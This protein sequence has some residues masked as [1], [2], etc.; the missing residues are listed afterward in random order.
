MLASFLLRQQYPWLL[1]YPS[2]LTPPVSKW[3][4]DTEASV[5]PPGACP[6]ER[7][8]PQHTLNM[9]DQNQLT[10]GA[11]FALVP[12]THPLFLFDI[13]VQQTALGT[14]GPA[15][16]DPAIFT[17]TLNKRSGTYFVA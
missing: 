14:N 12:M 10:F 7:P 11:I 3:V 2:C 15:R 6:G 1:S 5:A 16:N 17:D 9:N 4:R 13:F 8:R